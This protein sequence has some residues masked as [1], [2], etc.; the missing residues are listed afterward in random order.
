MTPN[1]QTIDIVNLLRKLQITKEPTAKHSLIHISAIGGF[2]RLLPVPPYSNIATFKRQNVHSQSFILFDQ[3][4]AKLVMT[5]HVYFL[6]LLVEYKSF[7]KQ[8]GNDATRY[9]NK[10]FV[11]LKR[12]IDNALVTRKVIRSLL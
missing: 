11:V 5:S 6:A 7:G 4:L 10:G 1:Q 9:H 8:I 12:G 2:L 3:E